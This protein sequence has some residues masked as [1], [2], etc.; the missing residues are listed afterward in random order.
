MRK[1]KKTGRRK[2][3]RERRNRR[4]NKGKQIGE[5]INR[6]EGMDVERR[7]YHEKGRRKGGKYCMSHK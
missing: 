6:G 5:R 4:L 2:K 1:R 7:W 3:K